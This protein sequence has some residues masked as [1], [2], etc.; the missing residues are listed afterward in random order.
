[1]RIIAQQTGAGSV[2]TLCD[3]G[4]EGPNAWLPVPVRSVDVLSFVQAAFSRPR[5]NGNTL[6][7]V[8]FT[9]TKEHADYTTAQKYLMDLNSVVPLQGPIR[10]DFEDQTSTRLVP[11]AT[12]EVTPIQLL[13]VRTTVS[14]KIQYG[15]ALI[16]G[17]IE[18]AAGD[19]ATYTS[20]PDETE[21]TYGVYPL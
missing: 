6:L 5:N 12:I 18:S 15:C 17:T 10:I 9:V 7:Q 19:P 14:Y 16:D 20:I 11:D 1:M 8:S 4:R 13:G 21:T 2:F 3:H